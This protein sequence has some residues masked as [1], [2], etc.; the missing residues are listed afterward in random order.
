VAVGDEHGRR[1]GRALAAVG[2]KLG[3]AVDLPVKGGDEGRRNG[4]GRRRRW[5][6]AAAKVRGGEGDG[7]GGRAPAVEILMRRSR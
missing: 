7:C 4:T 6:S 5:R 2:D 1:F 3:G